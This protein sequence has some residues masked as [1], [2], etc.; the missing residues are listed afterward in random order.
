MDIIQDLA[1]FDIMHRSRMDRY[2]F[3]IATGERFMP[4]QIVTQEHLADLLAAKATIRVMAG[5][6]DF[7]IMGDLPNLLDT[8]IR[9]GLI[10]TFNVIIVEVTED[11]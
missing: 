7:Q 3:R 6:R 4:G 2:L 8:I 5:T 10:E 9:G 11:M 1:F